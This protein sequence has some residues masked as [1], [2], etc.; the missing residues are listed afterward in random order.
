[1]AFLADPLAGCCAEAPVKDKLGRSYGIAWG[2]IDQV[3]EKIFGIP[4]IAKIILGYSHRGGAR[5]QHE[6][7]WFADDWGMLLNVWQTAYGTQCLFFEC[8]YDN[9]EKGEYCRDDKCIAHHPY[10]VRT[11]PC[12]YMTNYG[13]LLVHASS[14]NIL[15][16]RG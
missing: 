16:I 13:G 6:I 7:E 15:L 4:P 1:M 10:T 2:G 5:E 14:H 9:P 3:L 12:S 11:G 8:P